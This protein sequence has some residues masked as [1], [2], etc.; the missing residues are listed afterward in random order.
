M[1]PY[2]ELVLTLR[3]LLSATALIAL[4]SPLGTMTHPLKVMLTI[5]L[6]KIPPSELSQI[7]TRD[8]LGVI[9]QNYEL[10]IGGTGTFYEAVMGQTYPSQAYFDVRQLYYTRAYFL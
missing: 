2:W 10:K 4:L 9:K 8:S 3:F 1:S 5:Q 6:K 7:R